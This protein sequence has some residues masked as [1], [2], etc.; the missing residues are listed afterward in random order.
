M[1]PLYAALLPPPALAAPL[2]EP[3][4]PDEP[5]WTLTVDPLTTVLGFVH[6][7]VEHTLGSHLSLYAGPSLKL[8]DSPLGIATGAFKGY[9]VEAGLRAFVWGRAPRG[10]W[11][12]ARG[13]LADVVYG[14]RIVDSW[15]LRS[16]PGGYASLLAGYTGIIGPG[17]TLSGGLG[18][19]YFDY[20]PAYGIHGFLPAAHTNIGWGF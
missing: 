16:H 15:G 5:H 2:S 14:E 4:S 12:M 19:S 7:Q 6:V 1:F 8:F 20:G 3:A 17:I 13:V 11:V 10:A 18:V 9:G